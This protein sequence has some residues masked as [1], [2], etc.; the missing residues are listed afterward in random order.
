MGKR[1]AILIAVVVIA[2]SF[3]VFCLLSTSAGVADPRETCAKRFV[4]LITHDQVHAA[5]MSATPTFRLMI[6]ETALTQF[7]QKLRLSTTT[8]VQLVRTG[9]VTRQRSDGFS[10]EVLLSCKLKDGG[11][12]IL[13]MVEPGKGDVM[14]DGLAQIKRTDSG[15]VF[16]I[17]NKI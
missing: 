6:S 16:V 17:P 15:V 13:R 10:Y 14:V 11:D 5:W 1:A 2:L 8:E 7:V 3:T 12:V 4:E 9:V